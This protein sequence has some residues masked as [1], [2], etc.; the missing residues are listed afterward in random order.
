MPTALLK[1]HQYSTYMKYVNITKESWDKLI[2]HPFV[3]P[4]K[5]EA[6]LLIWGRMADIVEIDPVYNKPRCI[7]TNVGRMDCIQVD[8]DS[9][10]SIEEFVKCYHR[11]AFQLYTSHSYTFKPGDRFRVIFP[12][13]EPIQC[14][15]LVRPVKDILWKMFPE[16]DTTCFDKA[17]WQILPCIRSS[18][19]P[20][21]FLQHQGERLSFKSDKLEDVAME[22]KESFHWKKAIA[23][24]DRDPSANHQGMLNYVQKVFDGTTEGSRDK[25]VYKEVMWLIDKGC[26]YNE[27]ISLRP[28]VGFEQD[29]IRKVDRLFGMR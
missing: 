25:T 11:Y 7:G 19:A 12:L 26:D 9:V 20:Y 3:T 13:A 17:H 22:Y 16:V 1:P 28:P 29:Y 21:R 27:V 10:C 6:P 4:N 24:A 18:E 23:E 14:S 5:D 15:W 2:S 8:Y